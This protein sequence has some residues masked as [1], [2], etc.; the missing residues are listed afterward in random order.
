MKMSNNKYRLNIE[1]TDQ[2]MKRLNKLVVESDS[3]SKTDVIR[4]SLA[5]YETIM[6]IRKEDGQVILLLR[7]GNQMELVF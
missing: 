7:D 6:R 3:S 2:V 5:L 4:K 1:L